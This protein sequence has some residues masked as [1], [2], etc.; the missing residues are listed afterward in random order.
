MLSAA[1][2]LGFYSF[3]RYIESLSQSCYQCHVWFSKKSCG[4]PNAINIYIV[5]LHYRWVHIWERIPRRLA[6]VEY[7][8]IAD[9][10][11][12]CGLQVQHHLGAV[13]MLTAHGVLT[14]VAVDKQGVNIGT[15]HY[16]IP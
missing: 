15:S 12:N 6:A 16:T 2:R 4:S 8:E 3:G 7:D 14:K 9:C 5:D 10:T 11:M 13:P 1:R